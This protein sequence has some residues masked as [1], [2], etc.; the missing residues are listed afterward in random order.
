MPSHVPR[1]ARRTSARTERAR[2]CESSSAGVR[3]KDV[4]RGIDEASVILAVFV[5]RGIATQE[6][7]ALGDGRVFAGERPVPWRAI[8]PARTKASV[9]RRSRGGR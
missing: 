6:G 2:E 3:L 4:D 5:V 7:P 9:S 1:G 8:S